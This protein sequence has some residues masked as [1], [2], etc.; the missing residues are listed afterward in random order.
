[1]ILGLFLKNNQLLRRDVE[2][3]AKSNFANILLTRRWNANYHGVYVEKTEGVLSNLY[4]KNPDITGSDGTVYTQ[5]I[6]P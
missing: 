4:R 6:R 3:R 5:K 1:M 2:S